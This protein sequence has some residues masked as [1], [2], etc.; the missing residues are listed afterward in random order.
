MAAERTPGDTASG[1]ILA[2]G[3][4]TG[5]SA[6]GVDLAL[7]ETDGLARPSPRGGFFLPFEPAETAAILAAAERLADIREARID[8]PLVAEAARIVTARHLEALAAFARQSGFDMAEVAVV[9]MHGQTLFHDPAQR[10]SLQVGDAAAVAAR[11]GVPVAS[12]FRMADVASG[13]QGAPLAPIYHRLLAGGEGLPSVVV[14]IGGVTNITWLGEGGEVIGFDTGAGNGALDRFIRARSAERFDRDG[15]ISAEGRV[16]RALLAR[17][18]ESGYYAAPPPKS[19]DRSEVLPSLPDT[20]GLED[21]AATL[22]AFVAEGL[23]AALPHLPDSGRGVRRWIVSGG[24]RLNPSIL[25]AMRARLPG[26]VVAIED[27]GHDGDLVEAEL[28]A[29]LGVRRLKGIASTMPRPG[30]GR[31]EV[32]LGDLV[33]P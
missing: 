32:L 3:A 25:A 26:E 14:N 24:G 11:C 27:L 23:A 5:T 19:L 15:R 13:G 18:M 28:F 2:I 16:D 10:V 22:V 1:A 33:R 20:I 21:G 31:A 9:G 8:D 29:L 17:L 7:V 30:G 12:N 6:D 4:M